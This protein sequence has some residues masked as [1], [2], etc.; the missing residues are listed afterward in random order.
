MKLLEVRNLKKYF[1]V[2]QGFLIERVVGFVKAV[3]DVSFSVDR[4]K[5]IGIVGESGCG[6]TTIGK[7]IIRLHEVTDGEML[8]DEEDTTFYFMKK[9]RAK[10]YLKE[11]YFD[12]EK[13]N[14]GDGVGFEPFEKK[15]Y[16]IYNS[17][18]KD[19]SK[20]ID[21]LFDKSDHKKKLLRQKAQIVFQDP[22]SSLNPRMTVG[23][24]LTEPLLFH[25]L[26]KDLDEAVEMVKELLV[27]VGLKQYH[28]DRYPHQFSGGQRQR[29]AVARAISVNPDLIVLDEPTSALD[30]SVQAQIVNLFE[31]L[32][33]QLNAGYVFI[34]HNLSLVRFIS[35]EVSVMYLGRIVEQGNSESI[36]SSPLHPYTKALLAAAPIPDPK[37]KRNRKDLVG[38]Q[39]P[40]PIN[41]PSGC[42]FNPR[43]KY[44]MDICTK[45]YPPMF[46]A[47]ENHY[48]ACHLYSTSHEQ[49]GESK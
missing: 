12:T 31:K 28:V 19:S 30:V 47:D 23:Q 45:E 36:F 44:R 24:M 13:F 16:E 26:A 27:K 9:R 10:Q 14:N 29:I 35:Q 33:E 37:K 6:K 7:S 3:D 34:S 18:N 25:K 38:G 22:M 15:M 40:S 5:T 21:I 46:K 43:C 20:A 32:Q 4:G 1:P 17:V 49:G 48:V 39:V 2:K 41:R 8:I 11:K 42:F